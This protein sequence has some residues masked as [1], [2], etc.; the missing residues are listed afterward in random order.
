MKPLCVLCLLLSLPAGA[1]LVK[2][3]D[4]AK[5]SVA[6]VV[7]AVPA[8]SIIIISEQHGYAPHHQNQV[9]FLEALS[10]RRPGLSV[11]MEFISLDKQSALDEYLSG[12]LPEADFLKAVEWGGIPYDF[13]RAQVQLPARAGGTTV[14]INAPR[15][16]TGK[17]AKS[18]IDSLSAA[19]KALLPEG[20]TLGNSAYEDRFREVMEGHVSEEALER[21]FQA[22]SVWDE[23]MA[24]ES[25]RF[26]KA[27]PG[28]DF[29]IIV[30]DFHAAYGGGLP[31][32]LKARGCTDTYVITQVLEPAE[33]QPHDKWGT[34]S[35]WIWIEPAQ[36]TTGM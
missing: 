18:G 15:W 1:D 8:G 27:N 14:G 17:I 23:T 16:L 28:K 4:L 34:R 22:Q 21:Y 31:D 24:D 5:V 26:H 2:G 35:D 10:A 9:T 6:E 30:G 25:C 32:R 33:A 29:V 36:K 12:R 19:E 11:G 13:Y 20:F 7:D 3:A